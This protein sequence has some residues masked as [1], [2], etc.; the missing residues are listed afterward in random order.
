MASQ[1]DEQNAEWL[2]NLQVGNPLRREAVDRLHRLLL[3]AAHSEVGRRRDHYPITGP[4]LEDLAHDAA[5][6]AMLTILKKL[7]EFRGESRFTTWAYKFVIFEVSNK[8]ARH[9]SRHPAIAL[10][11]AQWDRLPDRFG[12]IPDDHA[13]AAEMV[14]A[15]RQ[16][17]DEE[18]SDHQKHVFIALVVDGIPLDAL[19]FQLSS[20]R[21]AIY[22]TMFDVRRKL[23]AALIAGGHI[24]GD[25]TPS[26]D[27]KIKEQRP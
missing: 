7:D 26:L 12:V 18:L 14:R 21:N 1:R 23:R 20:S 17:V 13:I 25:P 16:A 6:D 27:E 19:A 24:N 22:K 9:F 5:H 4:E 10:D 2:R 8:L 3:A 15:L 11:A